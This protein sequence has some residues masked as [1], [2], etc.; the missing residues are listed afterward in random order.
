[1]F[2]V[3]ENKDGKQSSMFFFFFFSTTP[4][5]ILSFE[6]TQNQNKKTQLPLRRPPKPP[7]RA[8]TRT[9][10]SRTLVSWMFWRLF[11]RSRTPIWDRTSSRADSSKS[12]KSLH[13]ER[14]LL[15]LP[16]ILLPSSSRSRSSSGSRRRRA[17]S[18]SSSAATPRARC[19]SWLGSGARA[20]SPSRSAPC[21]SSS[22]SGSRAPSLLLR[23]TAT[24]R[25]RPRLRQRGG[26]A[27]S[28]G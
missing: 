3:E 23:S 22:P 9:T 2:L 17:R 12:S 5:K 8:P 27:G 15:P 13:R 26:P 4:I 24:T 20:T 6:K 25:H 14:R 18:R 16:P 11:R 1:M 7:S 10:T 28:P 19:P 21:R